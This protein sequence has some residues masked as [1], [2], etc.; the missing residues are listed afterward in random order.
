MVIILGPTTYQH[1]EDAG[2]NKNKMTAKLPGKILAVGYGFSG[3]DDDEG[4]VDL[5]ISAMFLAIRAIF[6]SLDRC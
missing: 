2:E 5:A 3:E 4:G 6:L 1:R